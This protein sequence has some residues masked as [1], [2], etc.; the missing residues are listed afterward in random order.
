MTQ[1]KE[2]VHSARQLPH[3]DLLNVA[4]FLMVEAPARMVCSSASKRSN[5]DCLCDRSEGGSFCNL[6]TS[7]GVR[8]VDRKRTSNLCDGF[9]RFFAKLEL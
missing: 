7:E 1:N 9:L 6:I 8:L 3:I 2:S 4:G 5:G